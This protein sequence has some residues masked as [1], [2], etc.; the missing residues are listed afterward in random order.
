MSVISIYPDAFR[1][2]SKK[3]SSYALLLAI[4]SNS[5]IYLPLK[6]H[7]SFVS[8]LVFLYFKLLYNKS[9]ILFCK[10]TET[11]YIKQL[12]SQINFYSYTLLASVSI[13]AQ[14]KKQA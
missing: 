5:S 12:L 3:Y 10:Y 13:Y 2:I 1:V 8:V 7:Y 9:V 11:F 6:H 14:N 4:R